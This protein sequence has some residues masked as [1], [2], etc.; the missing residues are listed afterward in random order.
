V[1]RVPFCTYFNVKTRLPQS[2]FQFLLLLFTKFPVFDLSRVVL[3]RLT[4]HEY[5]PGALV[6]VWAH[7]RP[8]SHYQIAVHSIKISWYLFE[9]TTYLKTTQ[10][11]E[12]RRLQYNR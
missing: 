3:L 5:G 8:S 6:G 2:A 11:T 9:I 4:P 1:P 10:W 7:T 12:D